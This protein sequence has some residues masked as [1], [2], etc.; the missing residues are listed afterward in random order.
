MPRRQRSGR[1]LESAQRR[2]GQYSSPSRCWPGRA[3]ALRRAA[4]SRPRQGARQSDHRPRAGRARASQAGR[5]SSSDSQRQP[6]RQHDAVGGSVAALWRGGTAALHDSDSS[7]RFGRPEFRRVACARCRAPSRRRR[8][9]LLRQGSVGR[10]HLGATV[11][12]EENIIVGNVAL[13]G[14]TGGEAFFRGVAGERF[15]VRNSG[16]HA[17]VEGV[18]DHGCEYMTRGLVVVLGK[19]GRNFAAGMSGGVAYVL[20]EDGAFAS[21]SNLAMVELGPLDEEDEGVVGPLAS[22]P[23]GRTERGRGGRVLEGWSLGSALFVR[24]L[25]LE[26]KRVP[27]ARR[28]AS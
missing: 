26:Y 4:G 12:A 22:E 13:Y 16:A 6:H 8:E 21:R 1:A 20:D 11:K 15:A 10:I 3:A 23:G 27:D 9:R 7:E 28:E 17:V 5:N 14:A 19:T 24:G 25:P 2:F 18:G